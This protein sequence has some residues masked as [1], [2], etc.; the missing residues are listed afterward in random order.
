MCIGGNGAKR[1]H[2]RAEILESTKACDTG[3]GV[4][5]LSRLVRRCAVRPRRLDHGTGAH[6]G[7]GRRRPPD[8]GQACFG[9]APGRSARRCAWPKRGGRRRVHHHRLA[10]P[11]QDFVKSPTPTSTGYVGAIRR[12]NA[13]SG[14]PNGRR[15]HKAAW[16]AAHGERSWEAFEVV[17]APQRATP[18]PVL[19]DETRTEQAWLPWRHG[20]RRF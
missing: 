5:V 7:V 10:D 2:G 14:R 6:R 19:P 17:L 15:P 20:P 1:Q 4:I 3:D 16:V 18:R 9:A 12:D 8:A 11:H 13:N